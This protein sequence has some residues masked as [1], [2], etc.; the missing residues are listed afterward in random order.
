MKIPDRPTEMLERQQAANRAAAR[1]R[2][3]EIGFRHYAHDR[4]YRRFFVRE[5]LEIRA[6]LNRR[7]AARSWLLQKLADYGDGPNTIP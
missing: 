7:R 3:P 5:M 2:N 4:L 6:E 1:Y